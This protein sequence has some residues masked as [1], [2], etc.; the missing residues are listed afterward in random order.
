VEATMPA[1][2]VEV[3]RA[4]GHQVVVHEAFTNQLFGGAQL[5]MRHG[6]GYVAGSDQRKDG[7]AVG[8]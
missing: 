8:F 2:L 4:K 6:E 3:L 1:S 5:I 7:M